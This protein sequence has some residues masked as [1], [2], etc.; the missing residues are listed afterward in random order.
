MHPMSHTLMF[1]VPSKIYPAV[2]PSVQKLNLLGST[3]THLPPVI[4]RHRVYTYVPPSFGRSLDLPM[5]RYDLPSFNPKWSLQL[6]RA[7]NGLTL[8]STSS[9]VPTGQNN[10]NNATGMSKC[11]PQFKSY[12]L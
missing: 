8:P 4:Y 2:C 9:S 12:M 6:G 3:N 10:E 11:Q 1:I 5:T 7:K